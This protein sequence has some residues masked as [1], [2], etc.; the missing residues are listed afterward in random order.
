MK[1]IIIVFLLLI[2][3]Q[4]FSQNNPFLGII[5]EEVWL[6][7]RAIRCIFQD[8][9]GY[10]W[11]GTNSGLYQY[12]GLKLRNYVTV[13][14]DSSSI[15]NNTINNICEDGTGK[16]WVGT[17]SFLSVFDKKTLK[18]KNYLD[19]VQDY[20]NIIKT[21]D[22]TI[23]SIGSEKGLFKINKNNKIEYIFP[24]HQN[25][26]GHSQEIAEISPNLIL[27]AGSK[28]MFLVN[29]LNKKIERIALN[30]KINSVWV[31]SPQKIWLGSSKGKI[32]IFSL[33]N[34]NL[35]QNNAFSISNQPIIRING[36]QKNVL[37]ACTNE[38]FYSQ[39][40]S[41]NYNFKSVLK[42][43]VFI[44]NSLTAIENKVQKNI[45]IGTEKA[46]FS[47]QN[48][49]LDV[50]KI[51]VRT[52]TYFPLN[53][54]VINLFHQPNK[55]LWIAT[56]NDGVFKM[57]LQNQ[58]IERFNFSNTSV[59]YIEKGQNNHI[60]L[61]ADKNLIEVF[62]DYKFQ[63][64]FTA[65]DNIA[66][67]LEI[68][69]G[70]FWGGCWRKGIFRYSTNQ[71]KNP[72]FD[73]LKTYFSDKSPVFSMIKDRH[74]N[75]WFGIRGEGIVKANIKTNKI[76]KY[77]FGDGSLLS[78]DR[79]LS[80]K[81]DSKGNIWIATR[82][83]GLLLY[84][85]KKDQFLQF[86]TQ[87]GLPSNAICAISENNKGDI[88]ISTENGIAKYLPNQ[89]V[90][91]EAY[92]QDDGIENP[93]FSFNASAQI[94]ETIYFGNRSGIYAIKNKPL[95][96][97]QN[98]TLVWSDFEILD[99][100]DFERPIKKSL[101]EQ[102]ASEKSIVLASDENNI[103]ISFSALDF[104]AAS[105]I[106]YAYRLIGADQDWKITDYTNRR[107]QYLNLKSGEYVMEVKFS[108]GNGHWKSTVSTLK[109]SINRTFWESK[110][111]YILY[112]ITFLFLCLIIYKVFQNYQ[113]LQI[114]LEEEIAYKS[115]QNQQMVF[116][117]DL[118]HEIKNRLTLILGPLENALI[119]KKVNQAVLANLYEQA[120]RLKRINDQIMNIRKTDAGEFLLKVSE[121]NAFSF[122]NKICKEVE[123]LAMLRNIQLV[124]NEND[125]LTKVWFDDELLEIILL[126]IL[127]NAIKYT[128]PNGKV[129][130]KSTIKTLS[131][132][133]LVSPSSKVGLYLCCSVYDTGVGIPE[134]EIKQLFNRYYRASNTRDKRD[135]MSGTGLGLDLVARL[136]K[137][138]KG[139]I[140]IRSELN[141]F[142]EMIFYIPVEK[143]HF[144]LNEIKLSVEN[145]TPFELHLADE[146]EVETKES[147]PFQ[148]NSTLL[149][150]DDDKDI[151]E[152]LKSHFIKQYKIVTATN[153]LEALEI[154]DNEQVDFIISDWSMPQMDGL[155]L[156]KSVKNNKKISHVPFIMLTGQNAESQKLVCL[157][158]NVDDYIEKPFSLELLSWKVKN[159]LNAQ[160]RWKE[161]Q[162]NIES[163][164]VSLESSPDEIFIQKIIE[165]IEQEIDNEML[166]VEYLADKMNMSRSTFYRK[167]ENLMSEA[168]SLFIRKYRMKRAAQLLTKKGVYVSDVAFKVG[169]S[170]PKYFSKTF[171]K[172]FGC[173]P[174][175]YIKL[176]G[177][178][179]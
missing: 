21:S 62:P 88:F 6:P 151:L 19:I 31:E 42:N 121:N 156:L 114:K 22:G 51:N 127:N 124:I 179:N 107:I 53:N 16:I 113:K 32:Y 97:N 152:F 166:S 46:L 116:F 37:I 66:T 82:D 65:Q 81:E 29:I 2:S 80:L 175:E 76:R 73:K 5:K 165:N 43:N 78:S 84:N 64:V 108:D 109:F 55:A 36:N 99:T 155:S 15:A 61:A 23:L 77:Q 56:N 72:F 164:A 87:N 140:D 129:S 135:I 13:P 157:Q 122:I 123:P 86:T 14:T 93:E 110:W 136:I 104:E 118:S 112:F 146:K 38:L 25:L 17:G 142:T 9:E 126:N 50:E 1:K 34:G 40:Q 145:L 134:K 162:F 4:D 58:K 8:S 130:V 71:Q 90:L 138:H 57:N 167:M 54:D 30:D 120:Q 150:V 98:T 128:P 177:I 45:W 70:E 95:Q 75:V 163:N 52:E 174:A 27:I 173:T 18:F 67:F 153:G 154:V 20:P 3:F 35:I 92:N 39:K 94:N 147:S 44:E 69:P 10:L 168:P 143:E 171:Q 68:K 47:L 115:L 131:K 139:F 79:I 119:G 132:S 100:K 12:D 141:K 48:P 60:Y 170:N 106:K 111:G 33:Q 85:E 101:F 148:S 11:V 83:A 24:L 178:N 89:I 149:L 117:S 160:K 144:S 158:N 26:I 159:L 74:Q 105:K 103:A 7:K 161:G 59:R 133:D 91:F 63:S 169:F 96:L 137:L 172:E 49:L 41:A 176:N 28:G 102:L 125:D